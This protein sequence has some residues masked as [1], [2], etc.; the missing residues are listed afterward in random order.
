MR[1]LKVAT[2]LFLLIGVFII[3]F[4]GQSAIGYSALTQMNNNSHD[5]YYDRMMPEADFLIYRSNNRELESTMFQMMQETSAQEGEDLLNRFGDLK[6]E[7]IQLLN[8]L[9]TSG[10]DAEEK[11]I[12]REIQAQFSS[13]IEGMQA[14]LDIGALNRNEEAY[15]YYKKNVVEARDTITSLG[16][17]LKDDLIAGAD[18]INESTNKQAKQGTMLTIIIFVIAIIVSNVI[19]IVII[20][21]I[22][23]PIQL[24]Q[25]QMREMEQGDFSGEV[26]YRSKDELGQLAQSLNAML[27]VLRDL[28]GRIAETSQQV[29]AFSVELTAN[30]EQTSTASENIAENVEEVAGGSDHQVQVVEETVKTLRQMRDSVQHME[31]NA[32]TMSESAEQ[33][34]NKSMEGNEAIV[35]AVNQMS[36]IH[37]AIEDLSRI[38]H[39]L[40]QQSEEIGQIVDAITD[41]AAQTNLLALNA[42]IE[43]ARAGDQGRGFAVVAHEVRKLAE[44]STGAA[45]K[46]SALIS[47]IQSETGKAVQSMER[48][49]NEVSS[50]IETVNSAGQSFAQIEESVGKAA[51]QIQAISFEI[52]DLALG[53]DQVFHSVEQINVAA[54]TSAASTQN[55]AAATE[56]QLASMEEISVACTS[57]SYMA[58]ELHDKINEFKIY[59]N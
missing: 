51:D 52:R 34:S 37:E 25:K 3:A 33:A 32:Q 18:A 47:N 26:H 24:V 15:D 27:Q 11:K 28:F 36:S 56:E 30:A 14:V 40:E 59:K 54:Q 29:A 17:K 58:E 53:S 13:Y 21:M 45:Q 12:V 9:L 31:Q 22:V 57:L 23:K 19:G 48:T 6:E 39:G 4:G 10:I 35:T 50:G 41:I 49:A 44:Q 2:K 43:A 5:M 8:R 46:I 7:N 55:I 1:N 16:V 20:R 42:A 38:I